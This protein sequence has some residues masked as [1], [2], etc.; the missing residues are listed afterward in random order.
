MQP[1]SEEPTV[2]RTASL[3]IELS[4]PTTA[5]STVMFTRYTFYDIDNLPLVGSCTVRPKC[6]MQ[7]H[8]T[9]PRDMLREGV[10]PFLVFFKREK[11]QTSL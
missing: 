2:D 3:Q 1:A 11:I 7:Q 9:F 6:I 5:L 4:S 10:F 8:E